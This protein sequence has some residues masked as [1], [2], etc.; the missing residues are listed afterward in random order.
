M[1]Y[2]QVRGLA[3]GGAFS[4]IMLSTI[5][6]ESVEPFNETEREGIKTHIYGRIDFACKL[7]PDYENHLYY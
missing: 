6:R 1:I 7:P 2:G 4:N 5:F 3:S